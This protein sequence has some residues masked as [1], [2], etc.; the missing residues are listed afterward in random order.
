M[1]LD[2]HESI[3]SRGPPRVHHVND[4]SMVSM[5]NNFFTCN[6]L[7]LLFHYLVHFIYIL[8]HANIQ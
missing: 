4:S 2:E 7:H 5:S 6:L 1:K 3:L 8:C